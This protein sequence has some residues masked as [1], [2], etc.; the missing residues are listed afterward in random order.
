MRGW[1][2][3]IGVAVSSDGGV[4]WA[5]QGVALSEPWHLSYPFV[6]E[7]EGHVYMMPEGSGSGQLAL[8]RATQFPLAWA[9]DRVLVP[10][11]LVDASMAA[12][13]GHWY[14]LASDHTRRGAVKSGHLEVWHAA[15]PL[16][17]WQPHLRNPV[18][19]G[20]RSAGW[21]NGGRLVTHDG[22]LYR[23]G[24][25]CG[26]TYGHQVRTG[27]GAP[28]LHCLGARCGCT[29]QCSASL[30]PKPSLSQPSLPA[31]AAGGV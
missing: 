8:Y 9:R 11:P 10:R 22:R 7:H 17:P 26:S 18:G 6:F 28:A 5:H 16:G 27:A 13:Q 21:R 14:L 20:P 15:S 3:D 31:P 12:W 30:P 29:G 2:G 4:S 1:K 24:Q 23:F 19:N 25:D